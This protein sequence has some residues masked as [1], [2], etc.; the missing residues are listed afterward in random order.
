VLLA[1]PDPGEGDTGAQIGVFVFAFIVVLAILLLVIWLVRRGCPR[2][3]SRVKT[4]RLR[5]QSCGFDF[6]AVG[7]S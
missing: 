3:G 2:C 6:D 5:C 1:Y 7:R 4:G